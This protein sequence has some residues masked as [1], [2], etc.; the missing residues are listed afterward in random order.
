MSTCT[1]EGGPDNQFSWNVRLDMFVGF[2]QEGPVFVIDVSSALDGD[3]YFCAVKNDAGYDE[4]NLLIF[5]EYSKYV[6]LPHW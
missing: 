1:A 3:T 6:Y 5:G 4:A 2:I